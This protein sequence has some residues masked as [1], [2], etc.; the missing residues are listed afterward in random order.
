M[1]VREHRYTV[2]FSNPNFLLA[3]ARLFK[4]TLNN[5][6]SLMWDGM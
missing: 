4:I 5:Y 6:V 2:T 3:L 1:Y